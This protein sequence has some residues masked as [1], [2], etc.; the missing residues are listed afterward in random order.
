MNFDKTN[1]IRENQ[2]TA[3]IGAVA[4]TM[5]VTLAQSPTYLNY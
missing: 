5:F 4:R 2:T 3:V 1:N